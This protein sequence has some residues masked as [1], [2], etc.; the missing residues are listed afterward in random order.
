MR[1]IISSWIRRRKPASH[2]EDPFLVQKSVFNDSKQLI[3]FDVGA[4]VGDI[5]AAYRDIFP[6]ATIYCFEPFPDS[7]KKLSRLADGKSIKCYQRALCEIN[8]KAK[9]QVN[10]DPSCNSLSPRPKTGAR[11]YSN[12]A[13]NIGQVEVETQTLDTFCSRENISEIDILKLDVE[14]AE[15]KVLQ[16]ASGKLGKKQ[17]KLIYT[18]IVFVPHYEGGCLFCEVSDLLDKYG[19]TLF[20]LYNLKR[21]RNGQ[22]RWGNA[23]F[24]G[25]EIRALI[26]A[27][28]LQ[29]T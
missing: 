27:N 12:K 7:F 25:P 5:T 16:G 14:G 8:G 20:N 17:I 22:L 13:Q 15:I 2:S 3:I 24:A 21:A 28:R 23:I 19:Y 29:G 1:N 9:L 6:Q 10:S 4:Y 26:E 11:Y 18:E